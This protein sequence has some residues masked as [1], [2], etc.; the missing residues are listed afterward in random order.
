MNRRLAALAV[1]LTALLAAALPLLVY[2]TT[3]AAF[4]LAHVLSELRYVDGRFGARVGRRLRLW[5]GGL[6]ALVVAERAARLADW[7]EGEWVTRLELVLVVALAIGALPT[8]RAASR[9]GK[10][11]AALAL[12]A[13]GL[14]T[15]V[16]PLAT[17]MTVAVLHNWTPVGFLAEALRGE[18]RR[19]AM[20]A[21]AWVFGV[22]PL[23]LLTGLPGR[24]LDALGW[25]APDLTVL[26]TG[27]L[28]QHL[29]VYVPEAWRDGAFALPLFTTV[30]YAQCMH[31]AAVIHVLPGLEGQRRDGPL[32]GLGLAPFLGGVVLAGAALFAYFTVDF[33]TARSLYGLAAAVHAWVEVPLLLMAL[34][35]VPALTAPALA[36]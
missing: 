11:V 1:L 28:A 30:V 5:L 18:P 22:V 35:P 19:E 33:T 12:A 31:Y 29:W 6:L 25:H 26:P 10:L 17:I 13:L 2:S 20:R 3:L 4:G 15:L 36:R 24:G 8:L 9:G 23:I 16:H 32:S 34:A 7:I 27:A 21:C 14:G